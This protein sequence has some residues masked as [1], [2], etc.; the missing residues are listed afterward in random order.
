M[1]AGGGLALGYLEGAGGP[2]AV[3]GFHRSVATGE[4]EYRTGD[5]ARWTEGGILEFGGRKDSQAKLSGHRIE[6]VAID[7]A[8]RS[9][10]EVR[11]ACSCIVER[12]GRSVLMAGVVLHQGA[13]IE[14]SKLRET[15]G[16]SMLAWE[17]PA[18]IVVMGEIPI[19]TNGKPDRR[20]IAS[21]LAD[22]HLPSQAISVDTSGELE[23]VVATVAQRMVAPRK[24]DS[25]A[26][27]RGQGFDSL[28][29]LR[30][31]IDLEK[32]LGRPIPFS[33]I[34]TDASVASIAAAIADNLHR[35]SES[36]VV[37]HT[38]VKKCRTGV[39]CIPG[40]GG[41][42]FSFDP[43]LE[44]LPSWCPVYGLPYP[45]ISG[46]R[47]VMSRVGDLADVLVESSMSIL[48]KRPV[49]VGYSYGGFVAFEFARRIIE[50]GHEPVVLAIDTAPISLGIY[51]GGFGK[52]RN[53]KLKLANV[54]P[55]SIAKRAG[56]NGSFAMKHLRSVVAASFEAIR[57][58]DPEPL[59]VPVHLL[60][61]SET[62]FSPFEKIEDL[63]WRKLTPRV[64]I[65]YLPGR[66]LEVFRGA[67][68]EL[69]QK[70]R[71]LVTHVRNE[72]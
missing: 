16:Q 23:D 64:T 2:K 12:D 28:G 24:I 46:E 51:R 39:F 3:G 60:R 27:L 20:A 10:A 45:G 61:T 15:L 19:T 59:D 70:I 1:V 26:G 68:M 5:Y 41:T 4:V 50:R 33:D 11:D 63:G 25:R 32:A 67:S 52:L 9:E 22:S 65:D 72:S 36:L 17:V 8:L 42:V 58:Y 57:H 37:L 35:E 48:P 6:L 71:V 38:G 55:E 29:L 54:L 14:E 62:D 21:Q 31:A 40:V 13:S 7:Q 18:R 47:R 69:A 30:L 43:M 53:W 44:G 56:L 34:L 49:L 66:H